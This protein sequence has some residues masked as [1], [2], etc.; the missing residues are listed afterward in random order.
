MHFLSLIYTDAIYRPLLNALVFI[1]TTLAFHD[2]GLSIVILTLVVRALLHPTIIQ[3]IRSQ[4]TMAALQPKLKEM[5][6]KYKDD[7]EEQARQTMALYREMGTHPLAGCLPVLIQLPILIGLYRVFL[8][9]ILLADPALLYSFVPH[10]TS[11][12]SLAF[13]LIDL[14]ARSIPLAV[15]AG[16]SQFAQAKFLPAPQ[17]GNGG[18]MARALTFQTTYFLP[19]FIAVI[20]WRLPSALALYWTVFNVLAIVQQQWIQRRLDHERRSGP[21]QPDTR[22]NG[23]PS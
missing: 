8:K 3:T 14:T 9:G 4:R 21:N 6:K 19:I 13:G 12:N 17:S 5:Q 1:Y 16:V 11:F 22:K 18:D 7:K 10:I 23:N 2:L 15:L 20:S